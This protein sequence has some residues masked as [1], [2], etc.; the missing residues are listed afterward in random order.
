M[1]ISETF[2]TALIVPVGYA[3]QSSVQMT[4]WF[5]QLH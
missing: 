4:G 5:L 2:I 1:S 3:L